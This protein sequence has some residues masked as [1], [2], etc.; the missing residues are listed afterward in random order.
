[1]YCRNRRLNILYRVGW[2]IPRV[3]ICIHRQ[4]VYG[5]WIGAW[6]RSRNLGFDV[7]P[8]QRLWVLLGPM[9]MMVIAMAIHDCQAASMTIVDDF[10]REKSLLRDGNMRLPR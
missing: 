5:Y 3:S 4:Q 8:K 2:F 7:L 9:V 1:M 6:H 10:I